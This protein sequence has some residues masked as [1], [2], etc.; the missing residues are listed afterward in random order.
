MKFNEKSGFSIPL[1]EASV[2]NN[3]YLNG[4]DK[5][6]I[7]NLNAQ[8]KNLEK[9]PGLKVGDIEIPNNNAGNWE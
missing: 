4:L 9:F 3:V 6:E 1:F 2:L 5:Q 8:A 7:I